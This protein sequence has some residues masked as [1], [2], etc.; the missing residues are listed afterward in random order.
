MNYDKAYDYLIQKLQNELNKSIAY[1]NVS[2]TKEVI[3][4]AIIIAG[5][6]DTTADNLTILKTAA[7]FHDAG[8][9]V[10]PADH[11][12]H[13]CKLARKYLP[14]FQYGIV[15]IEIICNLI[16]ATKMPQ[17]PYNQLSK[18][19]CDADLYYLGGNE[20]ASQAE[21]LYQELLADKKVGSKREWLKIQIDFLES[22]S[23]FTTAAKENCNKGKSINLDALISVYNEKAY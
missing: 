22:H 16:M 5:A 15:Q 7:L 10:N 19:L 17:S 4:S 6:E 21:N 1:H 13:S 20:Y 12:F 23:Y 9:L 14:G 3:E 8:F 11:E 2:H 18:I